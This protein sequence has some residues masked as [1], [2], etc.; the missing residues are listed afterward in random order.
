[1]NSKRALRIALAFAREAALP[2]R[3]GLCT[4]C[5]DVV[6]VSGAG[7]TVMSGANAGPIGVS[8][9][10]VAALEDLQ[11]TLGEGPCRDAY[12]TERSVHAVRLDDGAVLRWPAFVALAHATGIAAVFTYPLITDGAKVGVLTLYQREVGDLTTNQHGDS[13]ALA[14]ILAETILSLQDSAP[15][16]ALAVGL[17]DA[18]DYRAHIY[19]ASGMASVQLGVPVNDAL[20]RIRAHAFANDQTIAA[21]A[22][23]ILSRQLRLTDDRN[24]P[25]PEGA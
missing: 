15:A 22:A 23:D 4:A 17:G 21:V 9:P 3:S 20:A 11:F 5:V 10:S 1:M 13:L 14:A 6:G 18:V 7:I 16:G 8:D 12:N 25:E 2:P 19:Q 24:E